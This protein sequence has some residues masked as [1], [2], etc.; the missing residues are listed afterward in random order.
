MQ[1]NGI[2]S[3]S[4]QRVLVFVVLAIIALL[5]WSAA[6]SPYLLGA[7]VA[8]LGGTWVAMVRGN[9]PLNNRLAEQAPDVSAAEAVRTDDVER[10]T[11]L[12]SRHAGASILSAFLLLLAIRP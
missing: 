4:S 1:Q 10:W 6:H 7:A 8:Y 11:C 5:D 2:N 12:D 9:V 3:K